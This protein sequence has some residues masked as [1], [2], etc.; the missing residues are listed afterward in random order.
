M[1]DFPQFNLEYCVP[2]AI[3]ALV[4]FFFCFM[5]TALFITPKIMSAISQRAILAKQHHDELIQ[6]ELRSN[7]KK[8]DYERL[9]LEL[10]YNQF[11]KEWELEYKELNKE[12]HVQKQR[13]VRQRAL[14]ELTQNIVNDKRLQEIAQ[15]I[16]KKLKKK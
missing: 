4:A 13:A 11:H 5:V 14:Q 1:Q 3:S 2:L 7:A 6:I 12:D 9:K 8:L 10:A 16:C 15:T